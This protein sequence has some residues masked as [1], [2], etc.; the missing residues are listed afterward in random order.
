[1]GSSHAKRIG[2]ELKNIPNIEPVVNMGIPGATFLQLK[3]PKKET[4]QVGDKI[5][6][7]PFG[8][9]LQRARKVNGLWKIERYSP[10]TEARYSELLKLLTEK[11]AEYPP[12]V[13]DKFVITNFYRY[14]G[15]RPDQNH[16]SGWLSLQ[17]RYNRFLANLQTDNRTFVIKHQNIV[18]TYAEREKALKDWR[19]YSSLQYDGLHFADYSRIARNIHSFINIVA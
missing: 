11:L 4:V 10:I 8:N 3:W 17:K 14:L 1:M 15:P 12:S 2:R 9:D 6:L 13:C 18:S 7:V 5:L 19:F 16:F